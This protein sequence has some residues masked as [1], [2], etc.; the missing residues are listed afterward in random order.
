MRA[1][2]PTKI[3]V[4]LELL[5]PRPRPVPSPESLSSTRA[6]AGWATA[7]VAAEVTAA[8]SCGRPFTSTALESF[9]SAE[10]TILGIRKAGRPTTGLATARW[11]VLGNDFCTKQ[12]AA[13]ADEVAATAAMALELKFRRQH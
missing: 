5:M 9:L 7:M 1:V 8:A 10:Q 13:V 12:V 2:T 4:S 3:H 6:N 11:L